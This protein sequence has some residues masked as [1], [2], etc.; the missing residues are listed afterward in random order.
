MGT[1][2]SVSIEDIEDVFKTWKNSGAKNYAKKLMNVWGPP[3]GMGKHF[4]VWEI[5]ERKPYIEIKVMDEKNDY[6]YTTILAK[7]IKPNH[8]P[9]WKNFVID[10]SK[11]EVTAKGKNLAKN[12]ETLSS[13]TTPKFLDI[14]DDLNNV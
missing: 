10:F 8:K 2:Q 4:V 7:K 13:I 14:H 12:D 3:T 11:L 6:V 9:E 5:E 1:S